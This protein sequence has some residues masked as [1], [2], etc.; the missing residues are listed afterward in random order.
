[1]TDTKK[2]IH[3]FTTKTI[4]KKIHMAVGGWITETEKE[5]ATQRDSAPVDHKYDQFSG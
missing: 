5:R 4:F 3:K 1:M 2:A